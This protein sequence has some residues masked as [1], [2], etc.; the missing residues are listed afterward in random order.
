VPLAE[1][2]EQAVV[3]AFSVIPGRHGDGGAPRPGGAA[4]RL[5]SMRET[6]GEENWSGP[7]ET[8]LVRQGFDPLESA[9]TELPHGVSQVGTDGPQSLIRCLLHICSICCW[10]PQKRY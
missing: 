3:T 4:A 5:S 9:Q 2:R 10:L 7:V 1:T 6:T 8:S